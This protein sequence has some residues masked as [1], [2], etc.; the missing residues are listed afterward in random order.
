[1][2]AVSRWLAVAVLAGAATAAVVAPNVV[3]LGRASGQNDRVG[4][5]VPTAHVPS[6]PAWV[7]RPERGRARDQGA[8]D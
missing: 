3:L 8:D 7:V 5:L 4:R 2:N 1:M 6:A